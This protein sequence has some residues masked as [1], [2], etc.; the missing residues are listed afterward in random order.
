MPHPLDSAYLP[1][2]AYDSVVF[3]FSGEKLKILILEY[4]NTGWFALPGGFVGVAEDLDAAV[5]RGLKERTGLDNIH[6]EQFHTFGSVQRHRPEVMR[7]I[8]KESDFAVEKAPWLLERFVSVGYYSLIDYH[9][10]TPRPD[11]LSDSLKWYHVEEL[12]P[13]LFDHREMVEKALNALRRNLDTMLVGTNMLPERF[14]IKQLQQ[15]T[16]AILGDKLHRTSFQ[17]RMLA[18]G[19]LRRHDKL[20]TGGSHKAP[21]LY[22]FVNKSAGE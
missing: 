3:G 8:L 6:L 16:E 5:K 20:Y 21:Y 9:R 1:H 22:S 12:P 2:L 13:L 10:V 11:A 14:T 18:T 17:R 19:L 15:V 4:H 7:T